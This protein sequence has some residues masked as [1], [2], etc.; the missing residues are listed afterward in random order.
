[1]EVARKRKGMTQEQLTA[2][3]GEKWPSVVSRAIRGDQ[4][5]KSKRVREK[6]YR[7]LGL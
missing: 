2:A 7:V 3:I 5:P 4:S 6:I 1:M